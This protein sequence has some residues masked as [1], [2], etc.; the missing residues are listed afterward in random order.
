MLCRNHRQQFRSR[1]NWRRGYRLPSFFPEGPLMIEEVCLPI[2]VIDC[3]TDSFNWHQLAP[4]ADEGHFDLYWRMSIVWSLQSE[5]GGGDFAD[6]LT[7]SVVPP[8]LPFPHLLKRMLRLV[9]ITAQE[10]DDL[11]SFQVELREEFGR[12]PFPI[13]DDSQHSHLTYRLFVAVEHAW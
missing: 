7:T 2:S 1:G 12:H 13:D 3:L 5:V 11:P 8:R 4:I 10:R 6:H 9:L